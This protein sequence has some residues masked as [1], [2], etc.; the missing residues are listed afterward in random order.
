MGEQPRDEQLWQ[1]R[2]RIC[3]LDPDLPENSGRQLYVCDRCEGSEVCSDCCDD[4]PKG[5][6]WCLYCL[7][8]DPHAQG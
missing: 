3:G 8:E 2:C 1:A 7:R 6:I 4:A 5:G